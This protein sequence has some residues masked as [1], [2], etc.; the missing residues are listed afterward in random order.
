[1]ILAHTNVTVKQKSLDKFLYFREFCLFTL[2]LQD[3]VDDINGL[4][5]VGS[6]V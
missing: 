2:S 4:S 6:W 1:M 5:P 3:D